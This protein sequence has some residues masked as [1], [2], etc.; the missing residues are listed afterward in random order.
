MLRRNFIKNTTIAGLVYTIFNEPVQTKGRSHLSNVYVR[1]NDKCIIPFIEDNAVICPN[2]I[3]SDTSSNTYQILHNNST[4]DFSHF[5]SMAEVQAYQKNRQYWQHYLPDNKAEYG[6]PYYPSTDFAEHLQ[7]MA[8]LIQHDYPAKVYVIT[9]DGFDMP[10]DSPNQ[11]DLK[12]KQYADALQNLE[13]TLNAFKKDLKQ[14][15]IAGRV[16]L[17]TFSDT[18]QQTV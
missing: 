6:Q 16:V 7:K 5:T 9:F 14:R 17:N 18:G 3:L 11:E 15:G 13:M 4:T 8:Y 1:F 2:T 10:N 12:Q